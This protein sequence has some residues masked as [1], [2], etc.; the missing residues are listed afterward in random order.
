MDQNITPPNSSQPIINPIQP[1]KR[2]RSDLARGII[3][4]ICGYLIAM[5]S[6]VLGLF[7]AG[8][9]MRPMPLIFDVSYWFGMAVIV[10]GIII[11]L[12]IRPAFQK[13]GKD[14]MWLAWLISVIGVLA[15]PL[16]FIIS[17][18]ILFL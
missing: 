15:A 12:I 13:W 17:R 9:S 14:K 3:S 7:Q 6:T 18:T 5:G 4:I 16:I 2:F 8:D 11:F 10:F 1:K